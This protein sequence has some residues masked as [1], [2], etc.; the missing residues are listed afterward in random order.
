LDV[1]AMAFS[2]QDRL[3]QAWAMSS[4]GFITTAALYPI[5]PVISIAI[6]HILLWVPSGSFNSLS[7]HAQPYGLNGSPA[8]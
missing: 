1:L 7:F 8:G 5:D 3:Q 6:S 4:T 2:S